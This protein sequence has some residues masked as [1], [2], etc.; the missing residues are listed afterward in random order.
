MTK[1]LFLDDMKE[2]HET[3]KR[4]NI[5][6]DITHVWDYDEAV[7]AL[8]ETKFDIASLDHDL[9]LLTI[10]TLPD[11]GEKSGY[12]VACYIAN[13]PEDKRPD[14]VVIHSLNPAGAQRMEAALKG[15]VKKVI[16]VPFGT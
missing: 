10:M 1:I 9:S 3:F 16:R 6:R 12:D 4:N 11:K 2:R 8:S 14:T 5:G 13:M 7:K 15:K